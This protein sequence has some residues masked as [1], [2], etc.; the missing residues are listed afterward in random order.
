M[1]RLYNILSLILV[2]AIWGCQEELIEPTSSGDSALKDGCLVVEFGGRT[3]D[4]IVFTTRSTVPTAAEDAIINVY[5][6]V[7]NSAGKKVYGHHFFYDTRKETEAEVT[8]ETNN[9]WWVDNKDSGAAADAPNYGQTRG[10]IKMKLP[11]A[12]ASSADYGIDNGST[13]YLIA[14]L[15]AAVINISKEKLDKIRE[16]SEVT[17]MILTYNQEST[18][19]TGNLLMVGQ[20]GINVSGDEVSFADSPVSLQRID[21]KV[22][23]KVGIVPGVH[24]KE[25]AETPDDV[26]DDVYEELESFVPKSWRV[27]NLPRKS[28]FIEKTPVAVGQAKDDYFDSEE[29]LFETK[30]SGEYGSMQRTLHGFSFYMFE[31]QPVGGRTVG[32]DYHL[33]DKRVK[34]A[35]GTYAGLAWE[36]A[37]EYAT[38]LVLEGEVMMKVNEQAV[39]DGKAQTLNANVTYYIHLGNLTS[40]DGGGLDNYD[41]NRNTCYTYTVNIKG[42]D[43][44]ELEVTEDKKGW[45]PENETQSGATGEVYIAQEEIYTFDAHYGQRV[46]TFSFDAILK[47]L[48]MRYDPSDNSNHQKIIDAVNDELTWAVYTPFGRQGKPDRTSSGVD[49]PNGLDYKWVYF[50]V[51]DKEADGTY[52]LKNQWFPGAQFKGRLVEGIAAGHPAAGANGK[53]LMDVIQFCNYLREQIYRKVTG[54]DNGFDKTGAAEGG[55][56]V[57]RVTAFVDENYYEKDPISEQSRTNLWHSFVNQDMRMMHILCSADVS[58]DGAS[59][60]TGSSVTIRQRSIQTV[61][62]TTTAD[63]GWGCETVDE[64]RANDTDR[65]NGRYG[66]RSMGFYHK[67]DTGTQGIPNLGNNSK[68][69]GLYNTSKLWGVDGSQEWSDYLDYKRVND[70][71]GEGDVVYNFMVDDESRMN[72]RYACLMRNR[73]DDG[74]N[75]IDKDEVKWYLASTEQLVTLFIGDLG[76]RGESQLYNIENPVATVKEEYENAGTYFKSHVVS[77][78]ANG[79]DTSQPQMVWAEEGC[80]ISGYPYASHDYKQGDNVIYSAEVHS[81]RC[82]RNLGMTDDIDNESSYPPAPIEIEKNPDGS[83]RF[84]M[85]KLNQQSKR[86]AVTEELIPLDE[87]SDM[88][89]VY[90]GFETHP[91]MPDVEINTGNYETRIYDY[92]MEGNTYCPVGYRLPNIREAAIMQN[93]IPADDLNFWSENWFAVVSYFRFGPMGLDFRRLADGYGGGRTWSFSKNLITVGDHDVHLRCVRDIDM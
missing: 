6:M 13:L 22:Q 83:Y 1:R 23:V 74:D 39:A 59:S 73:D 56:G 7:F 3:F 38:Y 33:R 78:T 34:N 65:T 35:D 79:T 20:T 11:E 61:Y 62:N 85:S 88:A 36:Y 60:S 42:V 70:Y 18:Y 69:N 91:D 75:V 55:N 92:F 87:Y 71:D 44:I 21:A 16:E 4:D 25:G 48:E 57:I 37:P 81:I 63:V 66:R 30:E 14:N 5:A 12:V 26:S 40:S 31:N 50:L 27:M 49:I 45:S 15:V 24:L 72:L 8:A 77:S 93:Y 64:I 58:R 10:V 82:V 9:C 90:S 53:T 67:T 19:R 54:Q 32:G 41:V 52:S 80:S 29:H 51:N 68:F 2:F 86:I 76:L 47:T 89:R 17:D 84:D 28:N 43:A 46:F